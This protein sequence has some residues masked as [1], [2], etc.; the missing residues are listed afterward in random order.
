M[1]SKTQTRHTHADGSFSDYVTFTFPPSAL[2]FIDINQGNEQIKL[3]DIA[4]Y[5]FFKAQERG[6]TAPL[7]V[8]FGLLR[9]DHPVTQ[10]FPDLSYM[11]EAGEQLLSANSF[12]TYTMRTLFQRGWIRYQDGVWQT[13]VPTTETTWQQ[14]GTAVLH[15]LTTKNRLHLKTT[16]GNRLDFPHINMN[17]EQ[18]LIAVGNCGFLSDFS[19]R[20]QPQLVFNTAYFLLESEDIFSYHSAL[21]EAHSFYMSD[22]IIHRP[23]LFR[24]GAIWQHEDSRWEVGLLGLDDLRLTLP[25]GWRLVHEKRP[26]SDTDRPFTLND[27][28]PSEITIYSRY[29]GVAGQEHVLGYTP[30]EP[31]RFELTVIDRRIVSWKMGGGL[32]LP[33]NGI[34]ISF[35]AKTLTTAAQK[36]F[37]A[38]LRDQFRLAYQFVA[39][40]HQTIR[41][42]MQAGPIL[43]V[44]GRSLLTNSYLEDVEQFW[45]SR[46]LENGCWQMGVVSTEYKTNVDQNRSGRVGM[47]IDHAGNLIVIM[48]AGVNSGMG[49]SGI[50]S[51]GATL[52]E[53]AELLQEA[54]A[55]TA[56]NLD[57]GGS[58]QAYFKGG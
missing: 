35:A 51:T 45:P 17:I 53:L 50:D 4:H 31:G 57:G 48:A 37:I 26:L 34:V 18:D 8:T 32:S 12:I 20:Q 9:P 52:L 14:N 30:L 46:T 49:V 58:T 43:L 29:Y 39:P 27:E 22:G 44:D 13:A 55:V 19:H 11:T 28:G 42:G 38:N 16:S 56:V 3:Q 5:R 25:N 54:G 1:I 10:L 2:D 15:L 21:G 23:P 36:A 6:E 47:G 24:R 40:D 7:I 41:Q 33:H